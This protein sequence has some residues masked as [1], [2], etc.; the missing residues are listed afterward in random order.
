M[1]SHGPVEDVTG[2]SL[3]E[4]DYW[5]QFCSGVGTM[6]AC[7]RVGVG[8]KSGFRWRYENGGM[9]PTRLAEGEHSDR[10]LSRFERHRIAALAEP[11]HGAREIARRLG[12]APRPSHASFD[13]TLPSMTVGLRRRP[14]SRPSSRAVQASHDGRLANDLELRAVVSEKLDSEWSPEQVALTAR[15]VPA[16]YQLAH[17]L[18]D[19][20]CMC[21]PEALCAGA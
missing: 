12:R 2:G 19:D 18:R 4:A 11:R 9:P 8:C 7:R 5:Q 20:R 13:G 3:L 1:K 14:H 10:Y 21:P 17:L 6:E 16:A 15:R